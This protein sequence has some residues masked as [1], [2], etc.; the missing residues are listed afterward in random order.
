MQIQLFRF[1]QF[2][3]SQWIFLWAIIMLFIRL[4]YFIVLLLQESVLN[5]RRNQ[6]F[7]VCF[8]WWIEA[9]NNFWCIHSHEEWTVAWLSVN[10]SSSTLC[11]Q[12]SST[13][14]SFSTFSTCFLN[15]SLFFGDSSQLP[16]LPPLSGCLKEGKIRKITK[17]AKNKWR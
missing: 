16:P 14:N 3:L 12:Q 5:S 6:Y 1:F 4:L 13:K 15:F 9:F 11:S 17:H 2:S 7:N 8:S 10:K